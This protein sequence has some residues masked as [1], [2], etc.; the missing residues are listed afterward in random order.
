MSPIEVHHSKILSHLSYHCSCANHQIG[1]YVRSDANAGDSRTTH[2]RKPR[3]PSYSGMGIDR[4]GSRYYDFPTTSSTNCKHAGPDQMATSLG[5]F[6]PW[7][8]SHPHMHRDPHISV[9]LLQQRC[10][11]LQSRMYHHHGGPSFLQP[12]TPDPYS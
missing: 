7:P 5:S 9:R 2:G 4:I 6:D 3:F 11:K 10:P 8:V 1:T 12:R